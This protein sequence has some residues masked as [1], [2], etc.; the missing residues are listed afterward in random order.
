MTGNVFIGIIEL[1]RSAASVGPRAAAE[2]IASYAGVRFAN[3]ATNFFFPARSKK[4]V[5]R[6]SSPDPSCWR[7]TPGPYVG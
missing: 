5:N 6:A 4:T 3:L 1:E 2:A 7:M